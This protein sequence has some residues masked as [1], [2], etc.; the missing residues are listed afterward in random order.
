MKRTLIWSIAI[1]LL[2]Q[3]STVAFADGAAN[4]V[5]KT[6][7]AELIAQ[8]R[9]ALGGEKKLKSVQSITISGSF[10]R[11]LGDRE[12]SGEVE[13]EILLP[14]KIKRSETMN[15]MPNVEITRIDVL[16]GE[17]VWS[18]SQSG[19]MGGMVMIRRGGSDNPQ[20]QEQMQKAMEN[21]IRADFART[22]ISLLLTS[23]S[24]FPVEFSYVGE[25]EAP[26]GKADAIDVT[27]PNKF[28]TRLFLDQK[29]HRPLMLSYRGRQPRLVMQTVSSGGRSREE[30]EKHMK[31]NAEKA[32]AE[33]QAAPE[34]DFQVAL[35]DFREVDGILFP[36]AMTRMVDGKVTEELTLKK[37]KVNAPIKPQIFEKK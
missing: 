8:A 20:I 28:A 23:Q 11:L 19:G 34:V 22:L 24:S 7:A 18:D 3:L 4:D 25:A 1:S 29:T 5:A 6:K 15:P 30:A 35:D 10:R 2:W 27:G 13:Y 17:Q 26:D 33:A 12:T 21:S 14:D 31:E 36:H 9:A 16:N 32:A 37:L